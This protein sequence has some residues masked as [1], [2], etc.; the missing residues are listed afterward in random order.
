MCKVVKIERKRKKK[1]KYAS[2]ADGRITFLR[3]ITFLEKYPRKFLNF[4]SI[5]LNSQ[6]SS[7]G[8]VSMTNPS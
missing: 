8:V 3:L 7:L 5:L 4:A 1:D 2:I 6:S